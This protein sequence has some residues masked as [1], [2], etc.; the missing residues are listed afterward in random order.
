MQFSIIFDVFRP[1]VSKRS[2][3]EPNNL[4]PN[5]IKFLMKSSSLIVAKSR[6][7]T[8]NFFNNFFMLER[9][10]LELINFFQLFFVR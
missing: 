7:E 2:V 5:D 8:I 9:C 3:G 6:G 1:D 4:L 10:L